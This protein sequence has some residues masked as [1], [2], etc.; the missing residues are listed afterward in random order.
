M[1]VTLIRPTRQAF[2]T[3]NLAATLDAL[4]HAEQALSGSFRLPLSLALD[5]ALVRWE[6]QSTAALSGG[7]A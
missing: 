1:I 4:E 5:R 3:L 6:H 2:A 7:A